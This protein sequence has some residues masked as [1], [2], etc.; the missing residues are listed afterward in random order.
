MKRHILLFFLSAAPLYAKVGPMRSNIYEEV[1]IYAYP[2]VLMGVTEAVVA[3]K[4][5]L[6]RF[7]HFKEF[8][9][10]LKSM[11]AFFLHFY[12]YFYCFI[13]DHLNWV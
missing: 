12:A 13:C 8:N 7:D 1:Y 4:T 5:P 2:L 10:C 9:V 11:L 3:N 6:N